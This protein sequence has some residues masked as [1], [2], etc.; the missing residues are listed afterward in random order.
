MRKLTDKQVLALEIADRRHSFTLNYTRHQFGMRTARAVAALIL[1]GHEVAVRTAPPT[2]T[3]QDGFLVDGAFV[4]WSDMRD[5]RGA[6]V[7]CRFCGEVRP[8]D[9]DGPSCCAAAYGA[10]ETAWIGVI[11]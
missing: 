8:A 6:Q 2:S 10:G 7:K 9:S 4:A 5:G 11:A 1:D 3:A